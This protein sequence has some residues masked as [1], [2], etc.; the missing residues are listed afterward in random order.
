MLVD[1]AGCNDAVT[2]RVL[3]RRYANVE[4]STDVGASCSAF[5]V[6]SSLSCSYAGELGT[7]VEAVGGAAAALPTQKR[8][9]E[10]LSLGP[11]SSLSPPRDVS[12]R[13][14]LRRQLTPRISW[15]SL[16]SDS[17]EDLR[18]GEAACST[19]RKQPASS[20]LGSP[21]SSP[22]MRRKAMGLGSPPERPSKHREQR[23]DEDRTE[24]TGRFTREFEN[25]A[26]VGSGHFSVV[27]RAR[28]RIDNQ[29]YAIK[30]TKQPLARG[31][32]RRQA[33]L[34]EA[35][36]L[37]S[38]AIDSSCPYIVRYF[39][40]WIE[41]GRLFIQTEL[42][43]GSLKDGL[44]S[45]R[46]RRPD[47]P[48]MD[49]KELAAVIRDVCMGLGVLH[50]KNLVH[51]DVKPE[52]ILV[53]RVL[54]TPSRQRGQS[55]IH[56]IADLGLATAAIG[57]GCDEISE[58]DS[59]YLAREVLQ[60]QIHDLPKADVFSLGL[61]CYELATNPRELPCNGDDWH[62]LRDGQLEQQAASH[63]S[64]GLFC[65]LQQMVGP[66]A[67][68]R[69][70]CA[71]ILNDPAVGPQE[72]SGEDSLVVEKLQQQLRKVEQKVATAEEKA[73]RYWSE[74]LHMKRQEMLREVPD[75]SLAEAK[76]AAPPRPWGRSLT[77]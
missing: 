55:R 35:L 53:K 48:R 24:T 13:N 46:K 71:E 58:G 73:D 38:V 31:A 66:V 70:P 17:H 28:N 42:C 72:L 25:A 51:L 18:K 44:V 39:S 34:H 11:T 15:M 5:S 19:P 56:K 57:S 8:S 12:T 60:G 77:A 1:E 65:L 30:R 4:P 37:A 14:E 10:A 36:A 33:M 63:L 40:S 29:E 75:G 50:G 68:E 69:P 67:A 27:Y 7:S 49:E 9:R 26:V 16:L 54:P 43:E 20:R 3:K 6:P 2:S 74:L 52:N 41:E 62:R 47:D 59:R 23:V 64:K 45:L 22:V 76:R 32:Q 21:P 61:M